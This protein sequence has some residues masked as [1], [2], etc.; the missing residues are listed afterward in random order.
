MAASTSKATNGLASIGRESA[1]HLLNQ[2][3]YTSEHCSQLPNTLSPDPPG[4]SFIEGFDAHVLSALPGLG[5]KLPKS[6]WAR[7]DVI[8]IQGPAASGKTHLLYFWA[9]TCIL[10]YQACIKAE[11]S[12][13]AFEVL[14]G[15]RNKYLNER[16]ATAVSSSQA[17]VDTE[18][19]GAASAPT[20]PELLSEALRRVHVFRPT[21][22]LSLATTLMAIPAYHKSQ[23]P[24][25]TVGMLMIDS[26]STFYWSD[27]WAAEQLEKA[28]QTPV[29]LPP[30]PD[31]QPLQ[32]DINPLRHV[33]TVVLQLRRSLGMVTFFTNWGLTTLESRLPNSIAYF[34]QHLRAPYPSP[35]DEETPR[36][37]FP[38]M[39]HIT[40]PQQGLPP[41]D[42]AT[43]LE[44]AVNDQARKEL[45]A[46]L[47]LHASVRTITKRPG[48]P[49]TVAES[50]FEFAITNDGVL[51]S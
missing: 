39:H 23:M 9:M 43:P 31:A 8:E 3:K 44:E 25:E 18:M 41:F 30:A 13:N 26:I 6:T 7:G 49:N 50:E 36:S 34:R 42:A 24:N 37:K 29:D 5:Q 28:S 40:V 22:T 14:L 35:F 46:Q 19:H 15:G 11:N 4:D 12:G 16:L 38:L 33:L 45:S 21:S 20:I 17:I 47:R 10:P 32:S 1:L 51:V 2:V 48:E 27:R